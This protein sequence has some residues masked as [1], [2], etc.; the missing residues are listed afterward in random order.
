MNHVTQMGRWTKDPELKYTPNG[1]PVVSGTIA[2]Q[3]K[4]KNAQG[5]YEA[6]FFQVVIWGKIGEVVADKQR[7]GSRIGIDGRLQS[8]SY[9][10][11]DGK[12]VYITEIVADQVDL[13]DFANVENNPQYSHNPQGNQ[14][15]G[16]PNGQT[17]QGQYAPPPQNQQ[18]QQQQFQ[19]PDPFAQGKGPIEVSDD[20]LPF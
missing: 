14:S 6:D 15:Q 1:K 8:R 12:R 18:Q 2:V 3:R 7:K 9:D 4:F 13:I 16:Q 19:Y 5:E 11:Q 20:D 10:G 17:G